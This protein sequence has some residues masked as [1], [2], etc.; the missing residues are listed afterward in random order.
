MHHCDLYRIC[1]LK[2]RKIGDAAL[3]LILQKPHLR[4][5]VVL[6]EIA[7]PS[8]SQ[9]RRPALDSVHFDVL[10]S[11]NIIHTHTALPSFI[12]FCRAPFD[13]IL[14]FGYSTP[15]PV[16]LMESSR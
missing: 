13:R 16:D 9:R 5:A 10:A 6:V 4:L 11:W 8:A 7:K 1:I 12:S 15:L 2:Q 3:R 14:L